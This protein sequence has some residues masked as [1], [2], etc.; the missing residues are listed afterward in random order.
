VLAAYAAGFVEVTIPY[1]DT[2]YFNSAVL[3]VQ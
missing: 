2:E 3:P 1:T